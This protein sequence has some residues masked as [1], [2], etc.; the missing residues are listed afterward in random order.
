MPV[1]SNQSTPPGPLNYRQIDEL[2]AFLRA[3]NDVTYIVRDA[4][5]GDA[6]EGP[7]D[8]QGRRR[9]PGWRDPKYQPAPDA[10]PYPACW[11]DEFTTPSAA[12]APRG[13]PG[14]SA[15]PGASPS[16]GPVRERGRRHGS[17][18]M[19]IVAQGIA[20]TTPAVIAPPNQ[21]FQIAFDNQD[22]GVQ[23]NVAI[24]DDAGTEVFKG[25]VFAGVATKTYD[26]PALDRRRLHVHL[27][28]PRQHDRDDDR[29]GMTAGRERPAVEDGGRWPRGRSQPG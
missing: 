26:V 28:G 9:S 24:K 23:H 3:T 18:P 2:I 13:R 4:E 10:T 21:A 22:A 15:A 20:F 25:E 8:R 7:A 17:P 16:A 19:S 6:P 1:W 14:A 12:P 27:L 5:L 11:E 29:Q